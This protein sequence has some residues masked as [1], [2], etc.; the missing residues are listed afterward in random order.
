MATPSTS[1]PVAR[2][3]PREVRRLPPLERDVLL[4][5]AASQADAEYR[6]NV[7]LTAFE[8]YGKDDL[9]GEST[10]STAR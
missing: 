3:S 8:A 6:T 1:I 9:H 7:E 4:R 2:L 10:N 5:A